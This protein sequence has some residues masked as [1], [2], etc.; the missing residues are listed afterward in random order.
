MGLKEKCFRN[1]DNGKCYKLSMNIVGF[2]IN[3]HLL[4]Y[5][6]MLQK[7]IK[8]PTWHHGTILMI[9]KST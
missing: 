2:V 5:F 7:F 6:L 9:Q 8:K 3:G 4:W 1:Q